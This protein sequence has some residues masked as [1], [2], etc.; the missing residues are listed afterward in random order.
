MGLCKFLTSL[1]LSNLSN[2]HDELFIVLWKTFNSSR[3]FVL[4]GIWVV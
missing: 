1:K 2:I 4:V 3:S